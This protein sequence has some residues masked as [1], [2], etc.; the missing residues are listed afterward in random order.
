MTLTRVG[1]VHLIGKFLGKHFVYE[2]HGEC[3]PVDFEQRTCDVRV[4]QT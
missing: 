1:S 4:R 3:Q 2:M